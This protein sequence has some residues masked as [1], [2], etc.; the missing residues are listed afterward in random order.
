MSYV[1]NPPKKIEYIASFTMSK[2]DFKNYVAQKQFDLHVIKE[3]TVKEMLPGGC[4]PYFNVDAFKFSS[5]K[6]N[7]QLIAPPVLILHP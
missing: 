1:F 5:I 7:G 4:L 2:D 6:L 3:A